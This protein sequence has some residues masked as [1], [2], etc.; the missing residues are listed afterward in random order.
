MAQLFLINT[1]KWHPKTFLLQDLKDAR[2]SPASREAIHNWFCFL[3]Y[4]LLTKY[5]SELGTLEFSNNFIVGLLDELFKSGDV[6][7]IFW[8]LLDVPSN[9]T[10]GEHRKLDIIRLMKIRR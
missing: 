9:G 4:H 8:S 10:Q 5:Q 6:L 2:Q 7:Y 1:K 3:V